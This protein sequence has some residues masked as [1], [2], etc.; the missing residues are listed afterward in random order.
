MHALEVNECVSPVVLLIVPHSGVPRGVV[1]SVS[2]RNDD[3]TDGGAGNQILP[4]F[5]GIRPSL[6]VQAPAA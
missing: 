4:V 5:D 2:F 3:I 6:F 1:A